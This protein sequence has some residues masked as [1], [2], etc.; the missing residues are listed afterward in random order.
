M[1]DLPEFK[2]VA[3]EEDRK[4]AFDKF[5]QRQ[6]VRYPLP[7]TRMRLMQRRNYEKPSHL[8]W[9]QHDRMIADIRP[10]T[11]TKIGMEWRWMLRKMIDMTDAGTIEIEVLEITGRR[12]G[13]GSESE[14]EI[15]KEIQVG[16]GLGIERGLGT[17]TGG[18]TG[19]GTGTGTGMKVGIE[20]VPTNGEKTGIGMERKNGIEIVR[21]GG[22]TMINLE[23]KIRRKVPMGM[24]A[25]GM[26][27]DAEGQVRS[28][29]KSETQR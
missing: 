24:T 16:T 9:D 27:A 1:K 15:G 18:R 11:E 19:T 20:V 26:Q 4:A 10:V 8:K 13:S 2:E 5:V 14:T 25:N 17:E 23:T 29:L 7:V 28:T 3:E 6:K 22:R 12:I 21:E